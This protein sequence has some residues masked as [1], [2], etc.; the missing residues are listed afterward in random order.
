MDIRTMLA[1]SG[2]ILGL[3]LIP[4]LLL[5]RGGNRAANRLLAISLALKLPMPLIIVLAYHRVA[6][7]ASILF[8]FSV[9]GAFSLPLLICYIKSMLEPDYR[10][11]PKSV[12]YAA[13]FLLLTLAA[14]VM[15]VGLQAAQQTA[16]GLP[17]DSAAMIGIGHYL[18]HTIYLLYADHLIRRHRHRIEHLFSNKAGVDFRG[19]HWCI[20]IFLCL[21]AMG[22]LIHLVRLIPGLTLWPRQIYSLA[23]IVVLYYVIA[24][25]ALTQADIFARRRPDSPDS[26]RSTAVPA[27]APRAKYETSAL[28][29]ESAER[30][31]HA[32]QNLLEQQ[33]PWLKNDLRL[34]E[35]AEFA[36]LPSYQLSQIINQCAGKSFFELMN[37]Y[38]LEEAKRLLDVQPPLKIAAVALDAGYNSQSVFYKHFKQATGLSP[39][40]YRQRPKMI[41]H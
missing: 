14:H 10:L 34:S 32:L 15:H 16:A 25:V 6:L 28:T 31:W 2:L 18:L 17:P 13:P 11:Q 20:R 33:R 30:Q 36:G 24:L 26:E 23:V 5:N 21:M 37:G 29:S 9:A 7:D 27:E 19:I 12:I 3:T 8:L 40:E 39:S 1:Y 22:L 4:A 38:R 35:L 41:A